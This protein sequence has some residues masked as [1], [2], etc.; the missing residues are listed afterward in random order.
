MATARLDGSRITDWPSFHAESKQAFGFP[1]TYGNTMDSWIDCL[2]YLRD[3]DGMSN[4]RLGEDE[5]LRIEL[6]HAEDLRKR[7]PEIVD[8]LAFCV[9]EINERYADYGE[10]PALDLVAK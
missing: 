9:A 4:V 2:S 7:Q 3:D 8:E 5:V 10:K 6:L 1:D